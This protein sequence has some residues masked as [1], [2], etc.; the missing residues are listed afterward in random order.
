MHPLNRRPSLFRW[1]AGWVALL[2]AAALAWLGVQALDIADTD[3]AARQ[4]TYLVLSMVMGATC[5]ALKPR[6]VG[7]L[8]Y[9]LFGATLVLLVFL[10][11]P[12][13]P[14]SIVP[15]VKGAR[16]W[17]DLGPVHLQPSEL[18]KFSAILAL[19]WFLRYRDSY[20]SLG[21]LLVPALIMGVPA[22]LVLLQPDLGTA[23][24][25]G[26]ALMA[27]LVVAGARLRHLVATLV[28]V[29]VV[30]V[31]NIVVVMMLPD[32]M[33]LLRTHQR[34]RIKA[35][36]V[37]TQQDH[38]YD[39]SI[40]YQQIKAMTLVGSGRLAGYGPDR[41][42][43]IV[44]FNDVPHDHNDM[45]F[46]IIVNRW[47]LIG[48]AVGLGL[49]LVMVLA[50]FAVASQATEPFVR[51]TA[52][53]FGSILFVQAA[54]NIAITLGLLPVTGIT[55]PLVSYGGSS[56]LSTFA[57]IGIVVNFAAQPPCPLA[58]PSFEYDRVDAPWR[59]QRAA[60]AS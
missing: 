49:Y 44:K 52:V 53:G 15:T 46:A 29:V 16:S 32:S 23:I 3:Y 12:G 47:G 50:I 7:H 9:G 13:V 6:H 25:F 43:S 54:I 36:I 42:Q 1:H 18:T 56:L 57:A 8:S 28:L 39:R 38:R 19:A 21:G 11:L 2:A 34:D 24:L 58:W 55:L 41:T 51:L 14:R 17:I 33:Q 4:R 40:N 5:L 45:I 31:V 59:R 37:R 26:P 35:M 22:G 27:M 30:V 20:R 10:L 60:S 48:G